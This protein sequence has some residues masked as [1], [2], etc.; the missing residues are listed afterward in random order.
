MTYSTAQAQY[1]LSTA[2]YIAVTIVAGA[3]G[4]LLDST[5]AWLACAAVVSLAAAA[6]MLTWVRRERSREGV[7]RHVAGEAA[8][9]AFFTMFPALLAYSLFELWA[10]APR[11]S[12]LVVVLVAGAVW[13]AW[14]LTIRRRLA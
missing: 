7:E 5:G 4:S 9:L 11:P 3:V 1:R 13:G 14:L 8:A 6:N 12:M 10:G 2:V